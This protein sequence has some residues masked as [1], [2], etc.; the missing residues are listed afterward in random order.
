MGVNLCHGIPGV[1]AWADT[2]PGAE[3]TPIVTRAFASIDCCGGRAGEHGRHFRALPTS[4]I[5]SAAEARVSRHA[6][7][8]SGMLDKPRQ[9][10]DA[11]SGS[12]NSRRSLFGIVFVVVVV[13]PDARG[14]ALLSS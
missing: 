13:A 8:L 1:E 2:Q 14:A 4:F 11:Q 12:V 3:K 10:P 7:A 9:R 6:S 5:P